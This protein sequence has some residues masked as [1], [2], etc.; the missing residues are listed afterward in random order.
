MRL[1]VPVTVRWSDL[2][3]YGHVNNVAMLRLLEEARIR[4]FWAPDPDQVRYGA[5]VPDENLLLVG[6]H[7]DLATFV[8]S[9]RIDYLKPLPYRQDPV[10]VELWITRLGG[11][12]LTLAYRVF[13]GEDADGSHTYA[14]AET[15]L[16]TVQRASG[17]PCRLPADVR[18]ALGVYLGERPPLRG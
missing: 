12:S 8:A 15:V 3:A 4:A 16:V 18:D 9:H 2:D 17:Q 14:L 11:S 6:A 1:A 10:Q 5:T 7:E 13:T